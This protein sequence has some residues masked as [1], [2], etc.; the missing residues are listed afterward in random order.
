MTYFFTLKITRSVVTSAFYKTCLFCCII[1]EQLTKINMLKDLFLH[2][3][4]NK[5]FHCNLA[6]GNHPNS[7]HSLF[8]RKMPRSLG[9]KRYIYKMPTEVV[10]LGNWMPELITGLENCYLYL[11]MLL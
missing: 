8:L 5:S 10:L 4:L 9:A 11:K 7:L 3:L 1:R 6:I 2:F